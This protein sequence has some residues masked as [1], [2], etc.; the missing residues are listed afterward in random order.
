MEQ[1]NEDENLKSYK[2]APDHQYLL[3]NKANGI[4][5]LTDLYRCTNTTN[6]AKSQPPTF[7]HATANR[8]SAL[9][10]LDNPDDLE[11]LA[12]HLENL[13]NRSQTDLF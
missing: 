1:E 12:N 9:A 10:N 5:S 13:S 4:P 3:F 8:Y 6:H 2:N 7:Q 11:N